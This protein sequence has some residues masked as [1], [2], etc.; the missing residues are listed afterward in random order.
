MQAVGYDR[1]ILHDESGQAMVEFGLVF[2]AFLTAAV[3]LAA[4]WHAGR[5]GTLQQYAEKAA[6]HALSSERFI[7]AAQDLLLY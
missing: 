3:V 2:F 1:D 6:S 5:D 4:L 7:G